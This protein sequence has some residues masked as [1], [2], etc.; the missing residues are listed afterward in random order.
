MRKVLIV[1]GIAVLVVNML[2]I[3]QFEDVDYSEPTREIEQQDLMA[4]SDTD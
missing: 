3:A 4:A 2:G 1:I